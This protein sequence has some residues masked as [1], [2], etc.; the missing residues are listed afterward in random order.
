M[1]VAGSEGRDPL[2]S[3]TMSTRAIEM[4]STVTAGRSEVNTTPNI[5]GLS[6]TS[7]SSNVRVTEAVVVSPLPEGRV[8]ST[9][10]VEKSTSSVCV[11]VCVHA[12]VCVEGVDGIVERVS[13]LRQTQLHYS[14]P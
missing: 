8:T 1:H 4:G 3:S 10:E 9:G 11:C 12:C 6:S 13:W 5:S 14:T 7:S 2:S